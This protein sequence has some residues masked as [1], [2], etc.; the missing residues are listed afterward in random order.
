MSEANV[1]IIRRHYERE[2]EA[3]RGGNVRAFLEEFRYDQGVLEAGE[4]EGAFVEG[5]WH[6]RDGVTAFL[7]MAGPDVLRAASSD[8]D[9][10]MLARLGYIAGPNHLLALDR[11]RL[12]AFKA[13]ADG[14]RL[15]RSELLAYFDEPTTDGY[16][17]G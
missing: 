9:G 12:A 2:A 3:F 13:L 16:A 1:E 10:R 4:E 6:G 5:G 14:V 17:E 15:W 11:A 8:E 7:E